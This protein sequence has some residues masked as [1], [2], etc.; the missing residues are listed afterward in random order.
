MI[1]LYIQYSFFKTSGAYSIKLVFTT[2][3]QAVIKKRVRILV[4]EGLGGNRCTVATSA[5][6]SQTGL[7]YTIWNKPLTDADTDQIIK[8]ESSEILAIQ[9]SI[10]INYV[11]YSL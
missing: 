9:S 8:T 1:S 10:K 5:Q 2:K 11:L 3:L 4:Y 7:H 6:Q